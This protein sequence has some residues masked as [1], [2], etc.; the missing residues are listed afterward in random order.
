MVTPVGL[1]RPVRTAARSLA[2]I[3]PG[4]LVLVVAGD[5]LAEVGR[6]LLTG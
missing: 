4:V 2:H 1:A 5:V 3:P 6:G